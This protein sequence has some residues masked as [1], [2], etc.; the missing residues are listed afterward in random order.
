MCMTLHCLGSLCPA[1]RPECRCIGWLKLQR[2]GR[3]SLLCFC[4]FALASIMAGQRDAFSAG[5]AQEAR[6]ELWGRSSWS[7]CWP[8]LQSLLPKRPAFPWRPLLRSQWAFRTV[9]TCFPRSGASRSLLFMGEWAFPPTSGYTT[10]KA[11]CCLTS[12]LNS[13]TVLTGCGSSQSLF[14]VAL[15]CWSW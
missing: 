15:R 14:V 8:S 7:S 6:R 4:F 5:T 1:W 10:L 2:T 12:H 11:F 13:V 9:P 3:A